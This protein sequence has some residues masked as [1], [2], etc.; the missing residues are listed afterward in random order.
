MRKISFYK[1][2]VSII[3]ITI[4][5]TGISIVIRGEAFLPSKH[6]G[7]VH[8][9]TGNQMYLIAAAAIL[10]GSSILIAVLGKHLM[11]KKISTLLLIFSI[12]LFLVTY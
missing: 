1:L 9:I 6:F 8:S 5:L 7:P 11:L 12:I 4:I 3:S 2:F 10:L